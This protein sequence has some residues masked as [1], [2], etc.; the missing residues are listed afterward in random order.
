MPNYQNAKI[1]AIRSHQTPLIYVGSTTQTLAQRMGKHRFIGRN[2]SKEIMKY[3]DAYIELVEHYPCDTKEELLKREGE[4]IRSNDCVNKVVAGRTMRE[5]RIDNAEKIQQYRTDNKEI[6]N[7]KRR[8]QYENDKNNPIYIEKNRT[9]CNQYQLNNK[10][11]IRQYRNEKV[12]CEC[13]STIN[14]SDRLRHSKS[15]KHQFWQT[16]YDFIYQ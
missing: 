1:Y 4:L 12:E 14:R 10:E 8:Q 16:T 9:S 3:E 6:I 5:Y 15:K 11:K 7:E 13:G 2:T